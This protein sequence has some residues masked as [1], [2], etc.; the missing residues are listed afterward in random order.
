[1][2]GETILY[3]GHPVLKKF[4]RAYVY[5]KEGSQKLVNSWDEYIT[6]C[7]TGLWFANKDLVQEKPQASK[8]T[9]D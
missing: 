9:K 4:F 8:K 1:M 5:G 2:N 7:S 6:A 3:N